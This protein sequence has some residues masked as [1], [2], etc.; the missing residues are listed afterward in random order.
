MTDRV[1]AGSRSASCGRS[2][3][4]AEVLGEYYNRI[5]E[6]GSGVGAYGIVESDRGQVT[7]QRARVG[8]DV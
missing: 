7:V 1:A 5:G 2:E 4:D 3:E 8:Y 6:T